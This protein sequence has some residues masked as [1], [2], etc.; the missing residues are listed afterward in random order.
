MART[1]VPPIAIDGIRIAPNTVW[2][3]KP[4]ED[5]SFAFETRCVRMYPHEF[6]GVVYLLGDDTP[7]G[8]TPPTR[9]FGQ[10][11]RLANEAVGHVVG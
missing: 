11:S 2:P 3:R 5:G 9:D 4:L 6:V 8:E 7:L 1:S 10:V